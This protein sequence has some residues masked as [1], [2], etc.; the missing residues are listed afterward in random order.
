MCSIN[1]CRIGVIHI[2]RKK[3]VEPSDLHVRE[4]YIAETRG[5][6]EPAAP[7][8]LSPTPIPMQ[9]VAQIPLAP[10]SSNEG[11]ASSKNELLII[12]GINK[13]MALQLKKLGI[14][15]IDDLAR[16]SAKN[17]AKNL[18]VDQSTTQKWITRAKELH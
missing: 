4:A 2:V 16:A 9:L 6:Y 7:T 18:Q 14:N 12:S 1:A 13:K 3:E 11:P 15:N 17:L 5:K 10:P 8:P